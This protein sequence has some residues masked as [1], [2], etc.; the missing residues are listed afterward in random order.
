MA[1]ADW[2]I[3]A[4]SLDASAVKRG[5]TSGIAPPNGGGSFVF[6]FNSLVNTP[7][8][9]ALYATQSGFA[10]MAK[11]ASMR[12][13][14]KRGAGGGPMNFSPFLF[15]G[16]STNDVAGVAYLL[17]LDDNDPHAI[18]LVKG[19]LSGGVPSGAPGTTSGSSKVLAQ[20]TE[21]FLN[22][23]W[24]H[25]RLDMIVNTNGDV[26]LNCYRND[27]TANPV[28]SPIW[29]PIPGCSTFTDDALQVNSGTAP[30]TSGYGGF[31][32]QTKD[33]TRR[34]FFDQLEVQKQI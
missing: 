4:N 20:G 25:L 14:V 18:A 10:P 24:L 1:E 16:L 32:F 28:T 15:A 17:G 8:A 3:V 5:V 22:N 6:G 11:G 34:A 27:V 12:A 30:L 21:T 19:P 23:T 26:I 13:A 29:T 33:I 31:G 7:G 9:V 2:V